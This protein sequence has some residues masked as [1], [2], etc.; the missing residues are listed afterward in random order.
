MVDRCAADAKMTLRLVIEFD[1]PLW[2]STYISYCF[3][4]WTSAAVSMNC[5]TPLKQFLVLKS[6]ENWHKTVFL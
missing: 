4:L 3:W 2:T 1:K 6:L 5:E